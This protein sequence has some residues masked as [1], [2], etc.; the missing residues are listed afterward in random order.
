MRLLTA[1]VRG[2]QASGPA[3]RV[4]GRT[5]G[6]GWSAPKGAPAG[7]EPATGGRWPLLYHL[8][9]EEPPSLTAPKQ[10]CRRRTTARGCCPCGKPGELPA[11][12][13][14]CERAHAARHRRQDSN[15]R[16]LGL[17]MN[18]IASLSP[19]NRCWRR[20]TAR[21]PP[22]RA[23]MLYQLSYSAISGAGRGRTCDT[24]FTMNPIAS[25]PPARSR[26]KKNAGK[27]SGRRC[28]LV[29]TQTLQRWGESC[30]QDRC[31]EPPGLTSPDTSSVR[32]LYIQTQSFAASKCV[33]PA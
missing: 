7:V 6:G 24:W 14:R 33:N 27:N 10:G 32:R 3:Q 22:F 29:G 8:S 19:T 30:F 31:D 21:G 11:A 16:P 9:Y 18:P 4:S 2:W 5:S 28:P 23:P 20:T 25:L 26:C 1:P 12:L 15:L 13:L 17:S